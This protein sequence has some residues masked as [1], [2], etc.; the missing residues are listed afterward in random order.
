MR[1][2]INSFP[3]ATVKKK[4]L[5]TLI[6]P[7]ISRAKDFFIQKP[8]FTP[9]I[10]LEPI[11]FVA[12]SEKQA[13]KTATTT[14]QTTKEI[15]SPLN[16]G[17]RV[18]RLSI[19]NKNSPQPTFRLIS[20]SPTVNKDPTVPLVPKQINIIKPLSSSTITANKLTNPILIVNQGRDQPLTK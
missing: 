2:V 13:K 8:N 10:E 4:P 18:I 1:N 14:V 11:G 20:S 16:N 15:S 9:F 12:N 3:L 6:V 5:T 19:Q 7:K 17:A